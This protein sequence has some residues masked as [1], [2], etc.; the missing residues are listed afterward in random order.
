MGRVLEDYVSKCSYRRIRP[1]SFFVGVAPIGT[2]YDIDFFKWLGVE[3]PR[4]VETEL[5]KSTDISSAFKTLATKVFSEVLNF[6]KDMDIRVE[7]A[8]NVGS[9]SSANLER[10]CKIVTAIKDG[11]EKVRT[12]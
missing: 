7:V 11:I 10:A 6:V 1:A 12:S 5:I 8:P 4:G 2:H 3:M 9:I